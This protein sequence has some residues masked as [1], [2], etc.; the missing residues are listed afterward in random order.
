[1]CFKNNIM[2]SKTKYFSQ[3]S[4]RPISSKKRSED[5]NFI[6]QLPPTVEAGSSFGRFGPHLRIARLYRSAKPWWVV[7]LR[8]VRLENHQSDIQSV[9]AR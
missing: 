7:K 9:R 6:Q 5:E 8:N 3:G 1:M 4:Q 2:K